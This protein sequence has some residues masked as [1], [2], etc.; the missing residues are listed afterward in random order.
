MITA[1]AEAA[2]AV[3]S[4][5]N[6]ATLAEIFVLITELADTALAVIREFITKFAESNKRVVVL[7]TLSYTP[8]E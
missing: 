8:D 2:L 5:L 4:P 6:V 1:L 3:I 7:T